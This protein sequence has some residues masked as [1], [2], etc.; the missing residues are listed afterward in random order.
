MYYN[1][2]DFDLNF[3]ILNNNASLSNFKFFADG[4]KINNMIGSAIVIYNAED[5]EIDYFNMRLS[6]TSSL[7]MSEIYAIQEEVRHRNDYLGKE[8]VNI[9]TESLSAL[10]AIC[11]LKED[12]IIITSISRDIGRHSNIKLWWTRAYGGTTDNERADKLAKEAT[13]FQI[14][15]KNFKESHSNTK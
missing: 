5:T 9:I 10:F 12:I 15:H 11:N 7:F 2:D 1:L 6:D 3:N 4:S 8:F 13:T 14:V